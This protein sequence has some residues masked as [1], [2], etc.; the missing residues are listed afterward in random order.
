MRKSAG[1]EK[2]AGFRG[3]IEGLRAVAVLGVVLFHAHMTQFGGGFVGVDVFYVLSGFLITGLLLKEIE[4]TGRIDLASFWGRRM[5]RLIPAAGLVLAITA[6]LSLLALDPLS[7]VDA[8]HDITASALYVGN[9]QFAAHAVDYLAADTAPSP[10]LHYWSLAVEEQFYII[11]PLL[12]VGVLWLGKRFNSQALHRRQIGA[13]VWLVGA[14]SFITS[15]ILTNINQPYA[16][17]GTPTRAW[18]LAMGAGIALGADRLR[19]LPAYAHA[20][21][22][23]LGLAGIAYAMLMLSDAN[24]DTPY[25]GWVAIIPTAAT[26]AVVIGGMRAGGSA[27]APATANGLLSFAPLRYIGRVSYSWY[28]WHWPPLVLAVAWVG[29]DITQAQRLSITAGTFVLAALTYHF[30]ENPVRRS[31]VLVGH[32][33][34]SLGLG[35]ATSATVVAIAYTVPSFAGQ[36]GTKVPPP[37][38]GLALPDPT[39][40]SKYAPG[41]Y[42]VGPREARDDRPVIYRNG[43]QVMVDSSTTQPT[44]LFADTKATKSVVLFGDSHAGQWF[45][46]LEAAASSRGYRFYSWTK[47][48][49]PWYDQTVWNSRTKSVY[50]ACDTW[51]T[52]VISKLQQNPPDVLV[53]GAISHFYQVKRDGKWLSEEESQPTLNGAIAD[54]LRTLSKLPSRIVFLHDTPH[55]GQDVPACVANH[56]Q[57][58]QLCAMPRAEAFNVN[59]QDAQIASTIPGVAVADFTNQLCGPAPRACPVVLQGIVLYRD[60]NHITSTYSRLLAPLFY[61]FLK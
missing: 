7:L 39:A 13:M 42:V 40:P 3:D 1:Q 17:F 15:L 11:W 55:R 61:K 48:G 47:S 25:P 18:Q 46:A 6:V 58:P 23:W 24:A 57:E 36:L 5:R 60:S 35:L 53:L 43:C 2:A 28:L 50:T 8:M 22:G 9:W 4:R 10:V 19:K 59:A 32:R 51:R 56:L 52:N 37:A 41:V 27:P 20:L 26:C 33:W 29:H 21:L 49:C 12:F 30:V 34:L 14:G 45:P 44:C 38:A 54:T 31:K 16:F